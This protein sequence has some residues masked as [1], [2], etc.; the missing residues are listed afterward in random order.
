MIFLTL[1]RII[2]PL[3]AAD[4]PTGSLYENEQKILYYP[5]ITKMQKYMLIIWI[6]IK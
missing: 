5:L 4:F 2:L 3:S 6:T 1:D